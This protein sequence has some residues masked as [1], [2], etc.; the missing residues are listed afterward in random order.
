MHDWGAP[1]TGRPLSPEER[2]A[3]D[4]VAR[5]VRTNLPVPDP[6]P[7]KPDPARVIA[8]PN[9]GSRR[10]R[11]SLTRGQEIPAPRSIK[12]PA[13]VLDGSWERH[14][15]NGRIVPDITLDLHGHTLAAAHLQLNRTLSTALA[16]DARIL[17][18]VTGKPRKSAEN[19]ISSGRGAIRAE[20]GHWL[21]NGPH[22]S[23]IASVR[24]AHPRH[25]GAGAL[26]I[27][28]RRKR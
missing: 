19:P 11:I 12:R 26:Y 23:H 13:D 21:S 24:T 10:D 20:I 4:K 6:A 18:V 22:A 17:L 8:S 27:I 28:L 9:A 3:W 1:V 7:V 25:G 2:A 15:R 14:I 5:T 16:Q